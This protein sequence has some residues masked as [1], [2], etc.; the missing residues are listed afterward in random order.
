MIECIDTSLA[1]KT[2]LPSQPPFTSRVLSQTNDDSVV[3]NGRKI[4][5][6]YCE[7][8]EGNVTGRIDHIKTHLQRHQKRKLKEMLPKK[9]PPS[10]EKKLLVCTYCQQTKMRTKSHH[11]E[12]EERCRIKYGAK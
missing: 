10:L 1:P 2:A 9:L 12:H 3:K 6:M 4:H 8:C 11:K 5:S 7:H